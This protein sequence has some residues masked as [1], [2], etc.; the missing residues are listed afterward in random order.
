VLLIAVCGG[1]SIESGWQL[2][3]KQENKNGYNIRFP[4]SSQGSISSFSIF[5]ICDRRPEICITLLSG[6]LSI[7]F[8]L[9]YTVSMEEYSVLI[10]IFR[11]G[12]L[13]VLKLSCL[14]DCRKESSLI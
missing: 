3:G 8:M 14:K 7:L 5:L 2:S 12:P 13:V 10:S 1:G 9:T 4:S 6:D 11:E